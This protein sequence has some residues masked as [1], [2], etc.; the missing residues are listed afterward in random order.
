M[1]S[2][3]PGRRWRRRR[4]ARRNVHNRRRGR[5][6]RRERRLR[7]LGERDLVA[8]GVHALHVG[9][10]IAALYRRLCALSVT[11][12]DGCTAKQ[13]SACANRSPGRRTPR[14]GAYRCTDSRSYS[15]PDRRAA[16]HAL[17]RRPLGR[18][19]SLLRRPLAADRIIGLK[20]LEILPTA[21]K[22]HHARSSRHG[23]ARGERQDSDDHRNTD[24]APHPLSSY[25]FG[26]VDGTTLSQPPG[27]SLTYG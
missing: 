8:F 19:P 18:Y 7:T 25:C 3:R 12:A 9:H 23:R 1:L 10:V 17:G 5:R 14:C 4:N 13:P 20:L 2:R 11:S 15:C 21:R 24:G 22:D 26:G 16:H 27:H 6:L